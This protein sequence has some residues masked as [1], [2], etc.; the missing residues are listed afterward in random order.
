MKIGERIRRIRQQK[1]LSIE[2]VAREM[3]DFDCCLSC[4]ESVETIPHIQMLERIAQALEVPPYSLLFDGS[5]PSAF[6]N[7]PNRLTCD[8]IAEKRS[9]R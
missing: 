9:R 3:G 5:E 7:L 4:I 2:D 6:P 8:D 1:Q